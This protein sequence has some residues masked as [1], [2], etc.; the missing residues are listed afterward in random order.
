MN[1]TLI[2]PKKWNT[3]HVPPCLVSYHFTLLDVGQ[4]LR[5][6]CHGGK[7]YGKY[8]NLSDQWNDKNYSAFRKD[9]HQNYL[10]NKGLCEGCPH[11]EENKRW[12]KMIS[13]YVNE[14]V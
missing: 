12:G 9:W 6:C 7:E 10:N 14:Q 2:D 8:S 4:N 13:D 11:H 3:E 1:N 5:F